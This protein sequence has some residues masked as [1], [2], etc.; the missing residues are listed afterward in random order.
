MI[1][2]YLLYRCYVIV[3]NF[4]EKLIVFTFNRVKKWIHHILCMK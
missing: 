4:V 1:G 2:V 3:D